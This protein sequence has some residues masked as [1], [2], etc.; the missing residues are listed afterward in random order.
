[1]DRQ[2]EILKKAW[3]VLYRKRQSGY[4][5][6]IF[7]FAKALIEVLPNISYLEYKELTKVLFERMGRYGDWVFIPEAFKWF[8][9]SFIEAKHPSRVL[10]P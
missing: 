3:D 7:E 10:I 2:E 4:Q 8:A 6:T 1:M 5:T 9:Q